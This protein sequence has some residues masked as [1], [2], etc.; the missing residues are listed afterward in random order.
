MKQ[1][2]SPIPNFGYFP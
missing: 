2:K 1:Q